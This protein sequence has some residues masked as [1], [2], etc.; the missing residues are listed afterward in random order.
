MTR[1]TEKWWALRVNGRI[2]DLEPSK[3]GLFAA[4]DSYGLIEVE[5]LKKG[6]IVIDVVPV[7][8]AVVKK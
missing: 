4:F 3:A 6:P 8:I 7:S 5:E 1:L 2:E